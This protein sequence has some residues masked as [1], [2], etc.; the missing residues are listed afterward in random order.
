[1]TKKNVLKPQLWT[2]RPVEETIAVY[3]DWAETYDTEVTERGYRTPDRLAQAL[4]PFASLEDHI[5]DFG[6]GTGISGAAMLKAGFTR[7]DGTDVTSEMLEKAANTG[8]YQKTWL[9]NPE[10]MDF[11]K[12]SYPVIIAVGV[13]SLGAAPPETLAELISKLDAGGI[14]A[15][16]YNGPTLED[17]NYINALEGEIASGRAEVLYRENGPHLDDVG[18]NSD[19]II[20]RRL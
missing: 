12:G 9:S 20:L 3:A 16:S 15:F 6:C 19:V 18:M 7:L 1:M 10:E 14:L 4:V 11:G 17:A 13:V 5:L 8:F 2:P